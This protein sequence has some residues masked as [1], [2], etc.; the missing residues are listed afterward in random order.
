MARQV[1]PIA[2][3]VGDVAAAAGLTLRQAED[4]LKALA[5]DTLATLQVGSDVADVLVRSWEGGGGQWEVTE[6]SGDLLAVSDSARKL[7]NKGPVK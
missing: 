3:Q 7:K 4:A 5:A 6:C 2:L 1:S